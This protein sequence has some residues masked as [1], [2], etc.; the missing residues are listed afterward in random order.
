MVKRLFIVSLFLFGLLLLPAKALA[1]STPFEP[2]QW[3][4]MIRP[5]GLSVIGIPSQDPK[6]MF[7]DQIAMVKELGVN[8]IRVNLE[9]DLDLMDYIV[10]LA[11]KENLKVTII[12]E[13]KPRD[14]FFN[15]YA[16]YQTGF[17]LAKD[18]A[19]RYRGKVSYYQ[20]GNESNG[21]VIKKSHPGD[22]PSDY[23]MNLYRIYRE[24]MKGLADGVATGD[25][26]AQRIVTA[27]WLGTA[28]IK[29]LKDDGVRFEIVGWNWYSEMGDIFKR[30]TANGKTVP[31]FVSN[32]GK[33]F[34]IVESNYS[35]GS[36]KFNDGPQAAYIGG[37]ADASHRSPLVNGY[38]VYTLPDEPGKY[39]YEAGYLGLVG[40]KR[41]SDGPWSFADKKPAFFEYKRIIGLHP[42]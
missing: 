33:K 21:A 14:D 16:S 3:G 22:R 10:N 5:L 31:E 37:T 41:L 8:H 11:Q 35:N 23:Y 1:Y 38:F 42:K 2:F 27:N 40:A 36:W 12:L 26:F 39:N 25:P 7:A 30:K 13:P 20:L 17:D 4:V 29:M 15:G 18:T 32:L 34:W 9:P 28:M 24:W 19:S 6:K